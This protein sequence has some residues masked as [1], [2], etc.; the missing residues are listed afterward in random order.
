MRTAG[1]PGP[2]MAL[3]WSPSLRRHPARPPHPGLYGR[4]EPIDV[5]SWERAR[6]PGATVCSASHCQALS[7]S[8][9]DRSDSHGAVPGKCLGAGLVV[10]VYRFPMP[11]Q[12]AGPRHRVRRVP[13]SPS[14]GPFSRSL[15][16]LDDD[17]PE[18]SAV[19]RVNTSPPATRRADVVPQMRRSPVVPSRIRTDG[20]HVAT[21]IRCAD[22]VSAFAV[23]PKGTCLHA[24]C[25]HTVRFRRHHGG[26]HHLRPRCECHGPGRGLR[27]GQRHLRQRQ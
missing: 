27:L 9:A 8:V 2:S 7:P 3:R 10:T 18:L 13:M 25:P 14:S 12:P 21:A 4:T 23:A 19:Q 20:D 5:T 22:E 17:T 6:Q 26:T 11:R 1:G 15:A 24:H 16:H